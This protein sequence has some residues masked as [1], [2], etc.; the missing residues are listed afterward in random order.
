MITVEKVTTREGFEQLAAVWNSLLVES[1]SNTLALTWEWL[2][3]WWDVFGEGRELYLLVVRDDE[4][5]LGIA[6]LSKRVRHHYN[7]LP[8]RRLEFLASGEDEADEICS[9]Y[10][11]F[12]LRRGREAEALNCIFDYLREH[13]TDWDELLL[14]DIRA[15][16]ANVSLLQSIC[17]TNET[18]CSIT[19]RQPTSYLPLDGDYETFLMRLGRKF[20][21]NLRRDR[22]LAE[23]TGGELRIVDSEDGF[24]E[25]FEIL[26]RLHQSCWTARSQPGVFSSERF[27]RFHRQVAPHLLR[28][29][30]LRLYVYFLSGEPV[31]ALYAF[32]Y[33]RKLYY[34][35]SGFVQ[36][37]GPVSSP[38]TLVQAL[39]IE[40]AFKLGLREFDFLRGD[41]G[42]YKTRWGAETRDALQL[43]IAH[44]Q[45]KEMV[46][47]TANRLV[48]G[49]RN[50]RRTLA[51]K[52]GNIER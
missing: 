24:A 29:G 44:S 26:V 52:Q 42:G 23:S 10:L 40:D 2:I 9:E 47:S 31:S 43:R 21:R 41:E 12:I 4:E 11:D 50:F 16:S 45:S 38:G 18:K 28:K 13:A 39:A 17:A 25:S 32:V 15:D 22:R 51:A 20:Q 6:P 35:Q 27:A 1:E 34:Y 30:W 33:E 14:T 46:Y 5:L 49:L 37:D 3:A 48:A 19:P 7:V 36:V 8:F